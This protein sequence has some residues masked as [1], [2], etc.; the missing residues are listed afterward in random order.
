MTSSAAL[1]ALAFLAPSAAPAEAEALPGVTWDWSQPSDGMAVGIASAGE[2]KVPIA[3]TLENDAAVAATPTPRLNV[4]QSGYLR[5]RDTGPGS[6][7][8]LGN[9]EALSVLVTVH[10]QPKAGGGFGHILSKGRTNAK[11][12]APNNLNYALRLAGEGN[13]AAL[14]FLF[15]DKAGEFHRWTSHDTIPC[16]GRERRIAFTYTFGQP[17][18]LRA[19]LDGKE[20]AGVWDM[21]GATD[22]APITDSD[23]LW[24]GSSMGGSAG[25]TFEGA[26]GS[27]RLLRGTLSEKELTAR[28][29]LVAARPAPRAPEGR[30]LVEVIDDVDGKAR[31]WNFTLPRLANDTYVQ[32]SF[33]V[34]QIAH[35]YGPTGVRVDR[36]QAVVVR[37]RGRATLPAGEWELLVRSRS[38]ARVSLNGEP[39]ANVR[40]FD[41]SS[42]AHQPLYPA[43]EVKAPGLRSLR[44]GDAEATYRFTADGE[45]I[46]VLAEFYAGGSGRRRETGEAGLFVRPAPAEGEETL[47][48]AFR[49]LLPGDD[50]LGPALTDGEWVVFTESYADWLRKL[51]QTRRRSAAAGEIARWNARHDF[52]RDAY[53]PRAEVPAPTEGLPEKNAVDRFINAKLAAEGMEPRPEADDATFLR[54]AALDVVGRIPTP[55][56]IDQFLADPADERRAKAVDRYLADDLG[57]ADGWVGEWQDVLAENPTIVNPTLNNTGPFRDWLHEAFFD[58]LSA[59]RFATELIRMNGS[60]YSGGLGGF[61]LASQN[62]A[63][64]AAK[65][66]V[67]GQAFLASDMTCARCHDAPSRP[68][69][70]KDLFGMAAMLKRSSQTVPPGSS[71]PPELV[72]NSVVKVTLKPGESVPPAFTLQ[73]LRDGDPAPELVDLFNAEQDTRERLALLVTDYQNRRFAEVMVNRLWTRYL[74]RGIVDTPHDWSFGEPSHPELLAYLA[75]ELILSGYDL[76]HVARLILNSHVY[77]RQIAEEYDERE[78]FAGPTRERMTAEQLVDSLFSAS[79]KRLKAGLVTIDADGARNEKQGQNFGRPRRAWEFVSLSTDRDRESL[80]VPRAEP[81]V[82]LLG[83]FGWRGSRPDPRNVRDDSPDVTQPALLENGVLGERFTRLSDDSRFTEFALAADSPEELAERTVRTIFTRGPNAEEVALF[84]DLLADGWS[85]RKSGEP[86]NPPHFLENP[87][88]TW[89]N[90]FI[91]EAAARQIELR[92]QV[93][94]GDPPSARLTDDWRQRYEDVLWALLNSPEFPFV[95]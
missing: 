75:D 68:F 7:L 72:E 29:P 53:T 52:T 65:A 2:Y 6:L 69:L 57:W 5:V 30:A 25:S 51:D 54:R 84:K 71:L 27:L 62:D 80:T 42:S 16:D 83:A 39:A 24:I 15:A 46:S 67:L 47:G 19:F 63:P 10:P 90:Q 49:L 76:K 50:S 66:H 3:G 23:D 82:E 44:P 32:D 77:G 64:F 31:S 43:G 37:V 8:T 78:L 4:G 94:A 88:V 41:R 95:P 45:P 61:A 33:A 58:N 56:E 26:I 34:P 55:E 11:G 28:P 1:L 12:R 93:E 35:A 20:T 73:G 74:G 87:G 86:A 36:G 48:E 13:R 89:T 81:F 85:E 38:G 91:S 9:G 17:D 40:F 59:D 70:Q 18:S 92:K 79:G 22:K 14:S 60:E 21:G